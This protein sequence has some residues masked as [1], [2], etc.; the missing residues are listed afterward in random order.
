MQKKMRIISNTVLCYCILLT[1]GC[2]P[3][4]EEYYDEYPETVNENVW[5]A[6][7]S[8]PEISEFTQVLMDY[9]LDTLFNSDIPY[10][11]FTPTNEAMGAF[12]DSVD[13]T[14]LMY[15]IC[16]HFIHSGSIQGKR[17]IQTLTEKFA[18]FER[19]MNTFSI[20]GVEIESESPLYRNGRYFLVNEVIRPK[21]NLY[22]YFRLTNPVMSNYIDSQDSIILDRGQST[23]IGFDEEG[24]TIYDTVS[25]VFNIFEY[26]YFPVKHEFR[27]VAVTIV[28]PKQEDYNAALNVMADALGVQY[29]D[30]N[31][32]PL[33]WQNNVL[34]PQ[35]LQQGVFLNMLEPHEFFRESEGD[36]K[37][38]MNI[39]GDSIVIN[40]TPI[41]KSLCSN[42]YAY[43]YQ[44]Y[45]IE[46][47]L[48][49]GG[50]RIEAESLTDLT[51]INKF[52]WIE[53]VNVR[54]TIPFAPEQEFIISASED[55]IVKVRFPNG[56]SDEFSVEFES[57]K[58]FPRKYVLEVRTHMDIG[59][60]Y[61]I[62]VNEELVK[63]FDY[64]EFRDPFYKGIIE[65]V[66]TDEY[67]FPEGRFNSFDMFVE[68]IMEYG[69]AVI[70]FEYMGPGTNTSNG[71]VLDYLEFRPADQH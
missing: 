53:G 27:D 38:L 6:M 30:Y 61:D 41:E 69:P 36:V 26:E 52:A 71:L 5:N 21:P 68:N 70:R 66:I 43:N 35:L 59:G 17:K 11:V 54:Q 42:G 60:I 29:N 14:L 28:F 15:H 55:T 16:S 51:G 25:V 65:S 13:Q 37:K 8:D 23:P 9:E 24:N 57:D 63:S 40:Y 48:Y 33:D 45:Q 44:D 10:A 3:R 58:L 47:S 64:E 62:Y 12:P 4:W 32:I 50:S 20:D 34:I 31:D 18:L 22:E 39:Q 2:N 46:D 56:Y 67:Y 49:S 1:M 7:Q 19:H